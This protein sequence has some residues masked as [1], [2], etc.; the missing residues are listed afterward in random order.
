MAQLNNFHFVYIFFLIVLVFCL[1]FK[2]SKTKAIIITSLYI[3]IFVFAET[4]A[5][6]GGYK[7]IYENCNSPTVHGEPLFLLICKL[8]NT[9]GVSYEMFRVLFLTSFTIILSYSIYK[10]S[11][12]FTLSFTIMYLV[13]TIYLVSAYRQFATM[14]IFL[15]SIYLFFF[16]DR[17]ISVILLNIIFVFI[18]K[19][20][21][22]QLVFFIILWIYKTIVKSDKSVERSVI[23]K[24]FFMIIISTIILRAGLYVVLSSSVA[25]NI[26]SR[27]T[28]YPQ[29]SLI[30]FGMI[31][32]MVLLFVI[33]DLYLQSSRSRKWD[34]IF[35]IYFLSMMIYLIMPYELLMGRLINNIR[36]LEIVLI[37]NL[38]NNHGIEKKSSIYKQYNVFNIKKKNIVHVCLLVMVIGLIFSSQMLNQSGYN[39]FNHML[40]R[41]L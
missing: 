15:L 30:N 22:V 6:Y 26:I 40:W 13:Y 31:S 2:E 19:V 37:P 18:H 24:Y 11:D 12:N 8:M 20:A 32:R 23:R 36:I 39:V 14:A 25:Y 28:S 35:S 4:G 9:V 17:K 38:L 41:I 33:T 1:L 27:I 3:L 34:T 7:H 21:V 29:T 16:K 5:D 10:L